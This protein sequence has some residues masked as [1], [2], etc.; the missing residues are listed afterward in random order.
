LDE[1]LIRTLRPIDKDKADTIKQKPAASTMTPRG[2]VH[3]KA[4]DFSYGGF[5]WSQVLADVQI[6]GSAV[7]IHV[8]RA[9]LCGISTIGQLGISPGGV[10]LHVNP[11]ATSASL[12]ET[13]NCFVQKPIKAQAQF[14]LAGE[15]N[16]PPIRENPARSMSGHLEFTSDNGRID[17]SSV[18]MKIFSVLNITEVFTGGQSDLTEK[19]YGYTKAYAK[20]EIKG[21]KLLFSEILLDGNSLKIT[22]LGF[23]ALDTRQ[24]DITLLAAPLK[25][26]DR[27]VNKIPI[28]NYIAG[29]S[30][31]S[32]PLRISGPLADIKV[33]PMSPSA[34]GEGLFNIMARALKAPFKL[35]QSASEFAVQESSG[36]TP[37]AAESPADGP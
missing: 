12:Q 27:I 9:N 5:T 20:A 37:R 34:V 31:I 8:H 11:T 36:A 1:E 24:A 7:D 2:A 21:G 22:G 30:L 17:H 19:G 28:V 23:I 32:I 13:A 4:N 33:T 35:V 26:I 25:T 14:D 29:G 3:V 18:L 6:D 15:I 10:S 16:L